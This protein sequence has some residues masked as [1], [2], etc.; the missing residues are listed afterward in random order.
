LT[1]FFHPILAPICG[2]C[3]RKT[4]SSVSSMSGYLRDILPPCRRYSAIG[5]IPA[6]TGYRR[7][8]RK[9]KLVI[10]AAPEPDIE[11]A[12]FL[13]TIASIHD[14]RVHRDIVVPEKSF[15]SILAHQFRRRYRQISAAG[16]SGGGMSQT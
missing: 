14:P 4:P 3:R 9:V 15:V 12:G 5:S 1:A 6:A 13:E 11:T 2:N 8:R 16:M 7:A 10:L